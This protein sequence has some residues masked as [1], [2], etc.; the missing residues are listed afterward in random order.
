MQ[1]RRCCRNP[2]HPLFFIQTPFFLVGISR[3][4]QPYFPMYA[5]TI[6]DSS[7]SESGLSDLTR[8]LM[9]LMYDSVLVFVHR[10]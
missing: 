5:G 1:K 3:K 2:P 6:P 9:S 10:E 4:I 7:V 8:P